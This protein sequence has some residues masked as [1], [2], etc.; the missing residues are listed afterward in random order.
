MWRN[1]K[2]RPADALVDY[3]PWHKLLKTHCLI[4]FWHLSLWTIVYYW[5]EHEM[6]SEHYFDH[7]QEKLSHYFVII[8]WAQIVVMVGMNWPLLRSVL[9]AFLYRKTSPYNLALMRFAVMGA[10]AGHH[11]VY[12]PAR[13]S[14]VASL[15]DTS[16]VDLP[17]VGWMIDLMPVSPGLYQFMTILGGIFCL[18]AAFGFKTRWS[19]LLSIPV[20]FYTLGVPNFYGKLNHTHFMLWFPVFL[21][22]S[23]AGEVFSVDAWLRGRK[24]GAINREPHY[25]YG[26]AMKL[27]FIQVGLLYFFSAMGKLWF[28][29]LEWALSDNLVHLM[30]LEWLENYQDIPFIR[31]D[32]YPIL[33]RLAAVGVIFF[34][35][36]YIF[37]ILTPKTRIAAIS[38]AIFFHTMTDVFLHINFTFIRNMNFFHVDVHRILNYWKSSRRKWLGWI[39]FTSTT[40]LLTLV[41]PILGIG[42]LGIGLWIFLQKDGQASQRVK[43]EIILSPWVLRVGSG[44]ILFN[45]A[46]GFFQTSSWPFSAYPSYSFVRKGVVKYVWF[47]SIAEDGSGEDIDEFCQEAGFRKEN[48]LPMAERTA[49]LYGF[50]TQKQFEAEL[51]PYWLRLIE[52]VPVLKSKFESQVLFQL[53]STNPDK[54]S[55]PIQEKVLGSMKR[56]G[57]EWKWIPLSE[58]ELP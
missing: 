43:R 49:F 55:E 39:G 42:F 40:L 51:M 48:I 16:K 13:L 36:A 11:F 52:K 29:G 54:I 38:S 50:R 6:V 56:A 31:L 57:K 9:A 5:L 8:L 46:F 15:P 41:N 35:L 27:I 45:I 7:F 23:P 32:N 44:L 47:E 34:E 26:V 22:F 20:L 14:Q 1:L 21:A 4:F 53:W 28:G 37:L 10:L 58:P 3:A 30:R 18:L 12:I 25:R 33:C 2:I 17:L 24:G 19:L